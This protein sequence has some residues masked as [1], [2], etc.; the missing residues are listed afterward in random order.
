MTIALTPDNTASALAQELL[1]EAIG[2][3]R[4]KGLAVTPI[5]H[6]ADAIAAVKGLSPAYQ[7]RVSAFIETL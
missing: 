1:G 7:K 5:D 6:E 3:K 4:L 2:A